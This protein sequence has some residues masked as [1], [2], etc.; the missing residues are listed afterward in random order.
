[1]VPWSDWRAR[2][3]DTTILSRE[4][5]HQRPY[6]RTPYAGYES[7]RKL[8]FPAPIDERY[9]PKMP[10]LGVRIPDGPARAYPAE[11]L[12]CA[13]GRVEE[14]FEERPVQ[15][16]YDSNDQVFRVEAPDELEVV[17]GYWFAWAAFHP[18]TSVYVSKQ[19]CN[20]DRVKP[21]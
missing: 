16:T 3:R 18:N 7:S 13:G 2:H 19:G 10:T 1:M 20:A 21:D 6:G 12:L 14:I 8:W 4:T 11:E 9:H 15:I 17:E 5:G